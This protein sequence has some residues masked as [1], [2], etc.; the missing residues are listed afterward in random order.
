MDCGCADHRALFGPCL[1][2]GEPGLQSWSSLGANR[3]TAGGVKSKHFDA[4]CLPGAQPRQLRCALEAG[5]PS[6]FKGLWVFA[7]VAH[8]FADVTPVDGAVLV[9]VCPWE[10]V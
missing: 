4:A 2:V 6:D 7:P 10:D 8:D 1:H 5:H 9:Q 3:R